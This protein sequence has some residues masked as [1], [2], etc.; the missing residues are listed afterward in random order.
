MTFKLETAASL[1]AVMISLGTIVYHAVAIKK[2]VEGISK[3]TTSLT[4][5]VTSL[6][7]DVKENVQ[8]IH[9]VEVQTRLETRLDDLENDTEKIESQLNE[10]F[11]SITTS[12]KQM[13]DTLKSL[14]GR[15]E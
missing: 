11:R 1:V 4:A 15:I 2:D 12:T 5:D 6:T 7:A 8:S 3:D 10:I 9:S 13:L 14:D